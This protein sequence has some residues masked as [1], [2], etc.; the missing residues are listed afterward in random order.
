[1]RTIGRWLGWLLVLGAL[2]VLMMDGWAAWQ[3]GQ[4]Q[5]SLAG[6]V[7]FDIDQSLGTASLNGVQAGIQRYVLPALWDPVIV[8]ILRQPAALV[9]GLPGLLL[10][11]LCRRRREGPPPL[12]HG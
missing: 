10:M 4:W 6:Q 1:M 7:W 9:L 3:G 12:F 11:F 8:W 5:F 2:T